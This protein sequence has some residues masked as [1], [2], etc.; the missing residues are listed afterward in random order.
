MVLKVVVINVYFNLL[1]IGKRVK[2]SFFILLDS[3]ATGRP[4]GDNLSMYNL[5]FKRQYNCLIHTMC[6]KFRKFREKRQNV[7]ITMCVYVSVFL[8]LHHK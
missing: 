6:F 7:S 3:Q 2:F 4:S 8:C 1:L 5:D